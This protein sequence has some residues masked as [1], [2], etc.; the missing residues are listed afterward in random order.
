MAEQSDDA[1]VRMAG[2]LRRLLRLLRLL[3]VLLLL[4]WL[5]GALWLTFRGLPP[6]VHIAG[7]WQAL[8]PQAPRFL[9]DLSAADAN[10]APLIERQ[11]DA[12]LLEMIGHARQM[13]L[14]DTGLFGD[15][16]AAGPGASRLGAAPPAAAGIVDALLRAKA[17]YP[18][19][20]V[21][22]LT[23]PATQRLASPR[24]LLAP[25]AAAGIEVLPVDDGRLRAPD[26]AFAA[27]WDI[28]CRWWSRAMPWPE[29]PNPL[30]VGPP[31]VSM[32]LWGELPGYQRSHRQLLI[33]DDGGGGVQALVFS[34]P[35][36]A[37]A[38]LHSATALRISGGALEPLLESEFALAQ[39][40]GWSDGG[41]MQA[42]AQRLLEQ[43]RRAAPP[44][45]HA[46]ARACVVT[47]GAI[48]AALVKRIEATGSG[49]RIQ[50]AALYLSQRA[51]VGALLD[52]ARRGASV[53]VLLDPGKDGYGYDRSGI[54]NREVA[55]ELVATSDG[56]VRVRWYRTHGEQFSPGFVLVQSGA[57]AWLMVGTAVL[58][59][60]DLD[61][62]NLAAAFVVELPADAPAAAEALSWF[63]TLWYNRV[64]GGT[65][66][67]ADADV[68]TEASELRY[69]QYR[70]FEA[71]GIAFD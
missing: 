44:V 43:Q 38:A 53:R 16:P 26:A 32:R 25:L 13:I 31:A 49:D 52:A 24:R 19:L 9:H 51:L 18:E 68:Y 67:T 54:P 8:P 6:G 61:D 7:Q 33:T 22:L 17:Q 65:E 23:D 70:L 34:R 66:F 47:E 27:F 56:A 11:I 40:S 5:L 28:C 60:R 55:S 4:G 41:A 48:A 29:W 42:R 57:N 14:L 3:P 1:P 20:S 69:W 37:E 30:G 10:G 71:L 63:D 12:Q 46:S 50:I 36:I 45:V 58:S 35:L 15:L 21:L 59:R 2:V 39:F 64:S 62:F